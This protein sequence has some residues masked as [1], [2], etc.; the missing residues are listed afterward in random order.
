M[1]EDIQELRGQ[2]DVIDRQL[3]ELFRQRMAVTKKVGEYKAA[4]GLPVLDR[5]REK[6]VL[7]A[8]AALVGDDLR[9]DITT[10]FETIMA[11]SRRSW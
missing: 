4:R 11:L 10:L 1:S 7:A 9:A 5:A 2:I 3:T 6:Q 8:K